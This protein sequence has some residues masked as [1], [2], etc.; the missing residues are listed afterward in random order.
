MTRCFDFL[1]SFILICLLNIAFGFATPLES[2]KE[3][4]NPASALRRSFEEEGNI[5]SIN[6]SVSRNLL[7]TEHCPSELDSTGHSADSIPDLLG[8]RLSIIIDSWHLAP[9]S[10]RKHFH[11]FLESLRGHITKLYGEF[12]AYAFLKKEFDDLR[13]SG[14]L[15]TT[16][17][18]QNGVKSKYIPGYGAKETKSVV[19]HLSFQRLLKDYT[20]GACAE[21][22]SL[23]MEWAL[24]T[25]EN[26]ETKLSFLNVN[27]IPV[28]L[29]ENGDLRVVAEESLPRWSLMRQVNKKF[30]ENNRFIHKVKIS[31][32]IVPTDRREFLSQ[33]SYFEV[34]SDIFDCTF[35]YYSSCALHKETE[36]ERVC[37]GWGQRCGIQTL[38]A[39]TDEVSTS[40]ANSSSATHIFYSISRRVGVLATSP[41]MKE[42][43]LER[44]F[45]QRVRS[46]NSSLRS[47][48]K[49][50]ESEA[51]SITELLR[52]NRDYVPSPGDAQ[53]L[54]TY[55]ISILT[56]F[57]EWIVS[58]PHWALRTWI[59]ISLQ[60]RNYARGRDHR[61]T[62]CDEAVFSS[63]FKRGM[64]ITPAV[65]GLVPI[66]VGLAL[67]QKLEAT[68]AGV[69]AMGHGVTTYHGFSD[70]DAEDDLFRKGVTVH[71]TI[72][73]HSD[74]G[75]ESL[76]VEY[77]IALLVASA[78][79][80]FSC[81]PIIY[82]TGIV[83]FG[84][85]R[86]KVEK[87]MSQNSGWTDTESS[88]TDDEL[89]LFR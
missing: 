15:A 61:E 51:V 6:S 26:G 63:V 65:V 42:S 66:M 83:Y 24:G 76:K 36:A 47:A 56:W 88:V 58:N 54:I 53:D 4:L 30:F 74:T 64:L 73:Y 33:R 55:L 60:L 87:D 84:R 71:M 45:R 38:I 62:S 37:S 10:G 9:G 50:S 82:V 49:L 59:Y 18:I 12:N 78:L 16:A 43:A 25:S 11:P 31:K 17:E 32:G 35:D 41:F 57:A 69:L 79:L 52:A 39:I 68:Q 75:F 7:V 29:Q 19:A 80:L 89:D 5:S 2:E 22:N 3:R 48:A 70:P 44:R 34:S 27:A 81:I 1:V 14:L 8:E 40:A 67:A 21:K 28:Q 86:G 72:E 77:F 85:L 23:P 46:A 20:D 13:S